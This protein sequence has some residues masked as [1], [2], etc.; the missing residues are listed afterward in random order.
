[1][2]P[3]L[4]A[5]AGFGISYRPI[6]DED[7]PFMAELYASTRAEEVAA[8][9][10][11]VEV[12]HQFLGQQ[13]EAQHRHYMAHYPDAEW[14]VIEQ[15]GAAIGRLYIE[16]WPSQ[17]RLIDIALMPAARGRGA[18]A[19][20][21]RDVMAQAAGAAKALS[22]H[23]EKNNPAMGLYRRLGFVTAEDKGVYDL[24]VW[25]AGGKAGA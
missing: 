3:P 24:L 22:I 9:G 16:E 11:P 5:A 17:F 19:A 15:G 10:W 14:L 25:S 12:Q 8:T 7:L 1:M 2:P 6:A 13:F 18:G 20:I 4:A 23:V 21:L